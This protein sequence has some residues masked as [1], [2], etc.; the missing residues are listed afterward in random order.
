MRSRMDWALLA[1][2]TAAAAFS[3]A[4]QMPAGLRGAAI[5]PFLEVTFGAFVLGLA[6]W[7]VTA[8]CALRVAHGNFALKIGIGQIA[9]LVWIYLRSMASMLAT[10]LAGVALPVTRTEIYLVVFA[11]AWLARKQAEPASAAR[12]LP[13]ALWAVV[14]IFLLAQRELPREVMPSSDPAQHLFFA[15][16][17]QKLGVVPFDLGMWGPNDFGYPAGFGALCALWSWAGGT[18][19]QNAVVGQPLLQSLLAVLA[20]SSLAASVVARNEHRLQ[21]VM[22]FVALLLF[23]G[24]FPFSLVKWH[25]SLEQAGSFSCLLLL[26]TALTLTVFD[27]SGPPS[28]PRI[29]ALTL[30]GAGVGVAAVVNPTAMVVPGLIYGGAICKLLWEKRHDM[31]AVV[32]LASLY[33]ATPLAVMFSDPYYIYRFVL[34]RAVAVSLAVAAPRT[35]DPLLIAAGRHALD[36]LFSLQWIKPFLQTPYFGRTALSIIPLLVAAPIIWRLLAPEKRRP[37]L[38][39]LALAPLP[40]IALEFTLLPVFHTLRHKGDLYLLAP[41]LFESMMRYG[42]IWYMAI[43]ILAIALLC[44]RASGLKMGLALCVLFAAVAMVP[45]RS[46]RDSLHNEVRIK[47][48]YDRCYYKQCITDDDRVVLRALAERFSDYAAAGGSMKFAVVPK[49]LLPNALTS[50]P[51]VPHSPVYPVEEWLSPTGAAVVVPTI[52]TFPAAFFYG[53]GSDDYSNANYKAHVCQD[54]DIAWL[55]ERNIRYL[56]V[57]VSRKD[58]CVHGLAPLLKEG[59]VVVRSGD[60]ALIE[61]F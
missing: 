33:V 7:A 52:P 29:M 31:V 47:P 2:L 56:F 8:L 48:R 34:R 19:A 1:V 11:L 50:V 16:Q 42:Y 36:I 35:D 40:V 18:S 26:L 53:K 14:A 13:G 39:L 61:L 4:E 24:F 6:G 25:D 22:G 28:R 55:R 27:A 37:A 3:F 23:F 10:K 20:V 57:P 9:L 41:Y 32:G 51:A 17:I 49:I 38:L 21:L 46:A 15:M 12:L 59:K 60:A 44:K 5:T 45:V 30:A 58:A 43:V 54:L